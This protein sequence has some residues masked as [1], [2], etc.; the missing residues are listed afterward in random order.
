MYGGANNSSTNKASCRSILDV[1][2][3]ANPLFG[4]VQ[5]PLRKRSLAVLAVYLIS[6]GHSIFCSALSWVHHTPKNRNSRFISTIENQRKNA[7]FFPIGK[8]GAS[9]HFM[10]FMIEYLRQ[11]VTYE[12][13]IIDTGKIM[14]FKKRT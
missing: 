2:L 1:S 7:P 10:Q 3:E 9:C 12:S 13:P 6:D 11:E 8:S 14:G 5:S 4:A